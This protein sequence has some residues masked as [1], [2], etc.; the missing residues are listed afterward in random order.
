MRKTDC[1][2]PRADEVDRARIRNQIGHRLALPVVLVSAPAGYGK[3]VLA[4]QLVR[5]NPLPH[6]WLPL[7]ESDNDPVHLVRSLVVSL[8]RIELADQKLIEPL[9]PPTPQIMESLLPELLR[10]MQRRA[11]FVMVI[12]DLHAVTA[13]Q[14]VA[15]VRYLIENLPSGC[16]IVL[17][18]RTDPD[19]GAARLRLSGELL[20]IR[21]DLLTFDIEETAQL[22][23]RAGLDLGDKAVGLLHSRTEGWPAGI[24]MIV[25]SLC[26][27]DGGHN[28]EEELSGR[29]RYVADYFFEEVLTRHTEELCRF[30]METSVAD[31]L[32]GQLCDSLLGRPGSGAVLRELERMNL[33]VVALDDHREWYRY[34]R[35][36]QEMLQ[37]EL[38]RTEPSARR[39]LQGR[40]AAWHEEHGSLDEAL[41]YARVSGDLD[42]AARIVCGHVEDYARLGTLQNLRVR[43]EGWTEEEIESDPRFAL[44]AGWAYLHLGGS[45]LA[46]RY[47]TA[48]G[49]GNLDQP[50][51][52][53][54]SSLRSALAIL[55]GT[56]G[57]GGVNQMLTDG[58]FVSAMERSA[59]TRRTHAGCRIAGVANVLLGRP[60]E[61]VPPLEEAVLLAEAQD[62]AQLEQV[63]CLG[64]LALA[65]LDRGEEA[66]AGL[67]A[68]RAQHLIDRLGL[69]ENW[70]SLPAFTANLAVLARSGQQAGARR[71]LATVPDRLHLAAAVPWLVAD[72]ASRCAETSLAIGDSQ[73]ASVLAET[74]RYGLARLPDAGTIPERLAQ[75]DS[76]AAYRSPRLATLTPAE[77]R[78]LSELATFRTLAEIARKLSVSRTTVKTHVASLYSKLNVS[79]RAQAVAAL[80]IH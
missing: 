46:E 52:S 31:R 79:T 5:H 77:M 37:A 69:G 41:D 56:A 40:A 25:R 34:H 28:L 61:A 45:P 50:C 66:R 33:F 70:M 24:G 76:N 17:T 9:C 10:C 19:I 1:P 32:C 18:S 68:S 13:P 65:H 27:E 48:A 26:E 4:A 11:P 42:R 7:T 58:L 21:A 80:G 59:R 8:D 67:L 36:F 60:D 55:R 22:L 51:P 30:L 39:A 53:G 29:W 20:E 57:T 2:P 12:D 62:G 44:G 43:L 47:A 16:Q 63:L 54:A 15:V 78:V 49:R 73:T 6:V 64:Y 23:D 14:G 75:L 71:E 72:V 74:A 38:D 3:S 35:L